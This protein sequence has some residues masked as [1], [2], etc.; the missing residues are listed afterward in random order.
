MSAR[1]IPTPLLSRRKPVAKLAI[2]SSSNHPSLSS[3]SPLPGTDFGIAVVGF[4]SH[5]ERLA[6]PVWV[7][8]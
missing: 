1:D 8:P 7:H 4:S 3:R 5:Q 2:K 6:A